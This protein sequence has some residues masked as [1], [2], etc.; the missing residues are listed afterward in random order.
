VALPDG[1]HNIFKIRQ[2]G[3]PQTTSSV[4]I[5]S[6]TCATTTG[7]ATVVTAA[8]GMLGQGAV[9][10]AGET[11]ATYNGTWNVT[12]ASAT[13]YTINN[14][15]CTASDLVHGTSVNAGPGADCGG[16]VNDGTIIWQCMGKQTGPT[17][18]ETS[19]HSGSYPQIFPVAPSTTTS[20]PALLTAN[21]MMGGVFRVEGGVPAVTTVNGTDYQV[22]ALGADLG[23]TAATNCWPASAPLGIN[24]G[25]N[26]EAFAFNVE[27]SGAIEIKTSGNTLP[28]AIIVDGQYLTPDPYLSAYNGAANYH[29]L[30]FT[31]LAP[32]GVR[33]MH[34]VKIESGQAFKL[35]SVN[36]GVSDSLSPVIV[37]TDFGVAFFGTSLSSATSAAVDAYGWNNQ[38]RYMMGWPDALTF[39]IG[40]TGYLNPGSFVPFSG[41]ALIDL[42]RW[43]TNTGKQMRLIIIEG[44]QNDSGGTYTNANI[45]TA[46]SSLV[47]SIQAAYPQALIVGMDS[48]YGHANT[49]VAGG[50][51][52]ATGT[53]IAFTATNGGALVAT[54]GSSAAGTLAG[55]RYLNIAGHAF[56]L[57]SVTNATTATV[58]STTSDDGLFTLAN[59][60]TYGCY[61]PNPWANGAV[62]AEA[63]QAAY[64]AFNNPY[65]QYIQ[66]VG[67]PP[68]VAGLEMQG[69]GNQT[70]TDGSCN[71][72]GTGSTT[73]NAII[74]ISGN[75]GHPNNC[76]YAK[77][78]KHRAA[79][80]RQLLF[81]RNA[82]GAFVIP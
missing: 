66:T 8:H 2:A 51:C 71:T 39:G 26:Y 45:A 3:D 12:V 70:S 36:V 4:S 77:I 37:P 18:T 16:P 50:T 82:A 11:P 48:P 23:G 25:C 75:D 20:N 38:L 64:V 6:I 61:G 69:T 65:I 5:T 32:A 41:H 81:T 13:S 31:G 44:Y 27:T 78:A 1:S 9:T 17:I 73:G 14:L 7:I 62:T 19:A 40:G 42:A 34:S 67:G 10:I 29:I 59:A 57:A 74:D 79:L 21:T 56:T 54:S 22:S 72:A 76:G 24:S 43:T 35:I 28:M 46:A 60:T 58:A 49:I 68:T 52:V 63:I 33:R 80:F 55:T 53:S 30:D 47:A 15:A